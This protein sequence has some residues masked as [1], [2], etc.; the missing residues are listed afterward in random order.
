M[1][2]ILLIFAAIFALT[3]QAENNYTPLK[4][5]TFAFE[6]EAFHELRCSVPV[7]VNY[8]VNDTVAPSVSPIG[9]DVYVNCVEVRVENNTL[10]LDMK[11]PEYMIAPGVNELQI[12]ITGPAL[13]RIE[14]DN[15]CVFETVGN[16]TLESQLAVFAS[17]SANVLL[18]DHITA[19]KIAVFASKQAVV[20]FYTVDTPLMSILAKN[21][22]IVNLYGINGEC[23]VD[24]LELF[25]K[26]FSTVTATNTIYGLLTE[27]KDETSNISIK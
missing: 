13:T 15:K 14:V 20:G 11:M 10:F 3:V 9:L 19:P 4:Q 5:A 1:K 22:S 18:R 7:Y 16:Q 26:E 2:K 21:L 8:T 17:D 12:N 23:H 6:K 24:K 25:V 27:D